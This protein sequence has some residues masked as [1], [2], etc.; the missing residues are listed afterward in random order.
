MLD[1]VILTVSLMYK[2]YRQL[3]CLY[4]S[5]GTPSRNVKISSGAVSNNQPLAEDSIPSVLGNL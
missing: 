1:N 5:T 2:N 3:P 4:K